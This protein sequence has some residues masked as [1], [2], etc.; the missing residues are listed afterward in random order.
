MHV[1]HGVDATAGRLLHVAVD[2]VEVVLIDRAS[3]RLDA[4]PGDEEAHHREAPGSHLVPVRRGHG[5]VGRHRRRTLP[6]LAKGVDVGAS[7]EDVSSGSVDDA[8]V[9]GL[10]WKKLE[11]SA[12]SCEPVGDDGLRGLVGT[13]PRDRRRDDGHGQ[14]GRD[15]EKLANREVTLRC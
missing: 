6:V 1:D 13:A 2:L 14:H 7:Q 15:G 11:R 4:R 12:R 3:G 10:Q 8:T 5:G 9:Q